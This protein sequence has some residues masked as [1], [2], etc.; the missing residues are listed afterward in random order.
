V[1]SLGSRLSP[2]WSWQLLPVRWYLL[3]FGG[4]GVDQVL[5]GGLVLNTVADIVGHR[6]ILGIGEPRAYLNIEARST[7]HG[8]ARFWSCRLAHWMKAYHAR[9]LFFV[10]PCELSFCARRIY[11]LGELIATYNRSLRGRDSHEKGVKPLAAW[12]LWRA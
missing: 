11:R 1:S 12:R 9:R 6:D 3:A 7:R 4:R 5:A 2:I 8:L 10:T